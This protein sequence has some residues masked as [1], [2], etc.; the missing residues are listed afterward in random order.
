MISSGSII[1]SCVGY[2]VLYILPSNAQNCSTEVTECVMV[3]PIVEGS[4]GEMM[5]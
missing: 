5:R 3:M 4:L 2:I 1:P